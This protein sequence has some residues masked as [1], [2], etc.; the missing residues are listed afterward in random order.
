[1]RCDSDLST[2]GN[3]FNE[4]VKQQSSNSILVPSYEQDKRVYRDQKP[5]SYKRVKIDNIKNHLALTFI[6]LFMTL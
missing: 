5:K 1:M 3:P 2:L 6:L 4:E